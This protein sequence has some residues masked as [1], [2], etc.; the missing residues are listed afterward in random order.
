MAKKSTSGISFKRV[1]NKKGS[2]P[3]SLNVLT[4][5]DMFWSMKM[6]VDAVI[7]QS[8][9][10]YFVQLLFNDETYSNRIESLI[11]RIEVVV[12]EPSLL[13]DLKDEKV[14]RIRKQIEDAK[15]EWQQKRDECPPIE[16]H[17]T[18]MSVKWSGGKTMIDM[19]V[20]DAVVT[21]I[22]EKK[23]LL[24]FYVVSFEPDKTQK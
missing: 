2:K 9:R 24:S 15:Q 12:N 23:T 1:T 7:D 10:A 6:K 13:N 22:N 11:G 18:V 21:D 3:F 19:S 14:R 17:A 5:K 16:F 8:H 4:L 20:P